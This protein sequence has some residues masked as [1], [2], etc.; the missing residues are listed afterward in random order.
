MKM[1]LEDLRQRAAMLR[2]IAAESKWPPVSQIAADLV[3]EYDREITDAETYERR[4]SHLHADEALRPDRVDATNLEPF[5]T[6]T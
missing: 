4:H 3:E 1:T 6:S 5:H 2:R